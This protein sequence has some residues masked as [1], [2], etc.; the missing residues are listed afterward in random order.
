M[1][2]QGRQWQG[3]PPRSETATTTRLPWTSLFQ[4]AFAM[5]TVGLIWWRYCRACAVQHLD[6]FVALRV[7]FDYAPTAHMV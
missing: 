3:S 1:V 4:V 5:I 6:D 2:A 7:T